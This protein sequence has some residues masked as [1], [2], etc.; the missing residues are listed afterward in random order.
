MKIYIDADACPVKNII[1]DFSIIN[2]KLPINNNNSEKYTDFAVFINDYKNLERKVKEF[3]K[4][5]YG[6]YSGLAIQYMFNG[7]RNM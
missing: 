7:M 5:K 3:C 2:L 4:E 6:K 1:E